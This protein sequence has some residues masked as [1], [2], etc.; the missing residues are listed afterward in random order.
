MK[1]AIEGSSGKSDNC[2]IWS[3]RFPDVKPSC[4]AALATGRIRDTAQRSVFRSMSSSQRQPGRAHHTS[5]HATRQI[6]RNG[7]LAYARARLT[8][9]PG[10]VR[11]KW[12]WAPLAVTLPLHSLGCDSAWAH[13]LVCPAGAGTWAVPSQCRSVSGEA[14][15]RE[16]GNGRTRDRYPGQ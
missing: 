7:V 4:V 5:A 8:C 16:W 2:S 15:R 10:G 11:L 6:L 12:R 1:S 3:S 14:V 13:R 9:E